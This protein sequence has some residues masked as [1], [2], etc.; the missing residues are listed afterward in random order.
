MYK[1]ILEINRER[2]GTMSLAQAR[3]QRALVNTVIN[4]PHKQN[5]I[6]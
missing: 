3:D 1:G 2:G 4:T 5:V 6:S